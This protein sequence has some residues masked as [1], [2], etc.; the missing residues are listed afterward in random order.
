MTVRRAFQFSFITGCSAQAVYSACQA[1]NLTGSGVLVKNALLRGLVDHR[2]G[3]EK[4]L[5]R[6]LLVRCLNGCKH[7][8]GS[9][10]YGRLDRLV[11]FLSD[12]AGQNTLLR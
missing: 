2:S 10:L 7:L 5:L 11:S 6:K 4:L 8:L 3:I 9:S 12:S 1:G